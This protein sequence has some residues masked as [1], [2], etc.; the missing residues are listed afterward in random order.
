MGSLTDAKIQA[1]Q[2]EH[3]ITPV[4]GERAALLEKMSALAVELIQ[5]AQLELSG[6]R[7]GNGCWHGGEPIAQT[8]YEMDQ[9]RD[10]WCEEDAWYEGWPKRE[11]P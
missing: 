11:G 7:D 10:R 3:G 5:I 9:L 8:L 2:E 1:W 4:T 6:I